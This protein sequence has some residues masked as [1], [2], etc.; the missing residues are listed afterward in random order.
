M[1]VSLDI[2]SG[3]VG[4]TF[5]FQSLKITFLAMETKILPQAGHPL[6]MGKML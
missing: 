3:E 6:T 1:G 2:H 5:H 4:G